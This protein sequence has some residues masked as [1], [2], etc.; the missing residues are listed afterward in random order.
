MLELLDGIA[1]ALGRAHARKVHVP[2]G[3]MRPLARILHHL[4]GFP[5]T[6][7]QLLMLEEDNVCDPRP[8]NSTFGLTPLPLATG[9]ARMLE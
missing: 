1:R 7:D 8:F 4:P 5:V 2:L 6:P 9:L 3:L